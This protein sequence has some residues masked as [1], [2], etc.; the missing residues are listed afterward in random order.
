MHP[1]ALEAIYRPQSCLGNELRVFAIS[2][3]TSAFKDLSGNPCRLCS[4]ALALG[5]LLILFLK[6]LLWNT[7][8]SKTDHVDHLCNLRKTA[9][10]TTLLWCNDEKQKI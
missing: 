1:A 4:V 5:D 7:V 10:A 2:L 8:L 3:C 9:A 6:S